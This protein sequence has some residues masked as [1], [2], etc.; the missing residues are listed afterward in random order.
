MASP[1]IDLGTMPSTDSCYPLASS[2][3]KYF[4]ALY[5]SRD[6]DDKDLQ[7]MPSKG[8]AVVEYRVRSR[9][10]SEDGDGKKRTSADIE[11]QSIE[12]IT[13]KVRALSAKIDAHL[14]EF[15]DGIEDPRPRDPMGQFSGAQTQGLDPMTMKQAYK[16]RR[17][18]SLAR[19][20]GM[21]ARGVALR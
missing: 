10:V 8:K 18:P 1:K 2:S 14:H 3:R 20:G 11:I 15:A 4:P 19:I 13:N 21:A 5:V 7:G 6:S 12:P 16:K 9:T 17:L